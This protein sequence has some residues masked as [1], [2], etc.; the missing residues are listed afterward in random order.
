MISKDKIK[1]QITITKELDEVLNQIVEGARKT[2]NPLSKS[3]LTEV[4]LRTFIANSIESQ[5]KVKE[6]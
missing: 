5:K 4:A 1:L 2:N 3:Q 6:S